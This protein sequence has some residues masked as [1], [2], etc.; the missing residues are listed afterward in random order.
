FIGDKTMFITEGRIKIKTDMFIAGRNV[1]VTDITFDNA[2][3]IECQVF[4]SLGKVNSCL[5]RQLNIIAEHIVLANQFTSND[6][7]LEANKEFLSIGC[8]IKSP[9]HLKIKAPRPFLSAVICNHSVETTTY[10]VR[11]RLLNGEIFER[12]ISV[13]TGEYHEDSIDASVRMIKEKLDELDM[14]RE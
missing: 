3:T 7:C 13:I 2:D 4:L 6:I 11:E 8:M 5:E 9:G 14:E 10:T 1:I 12:K